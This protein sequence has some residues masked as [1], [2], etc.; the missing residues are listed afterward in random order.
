MANN[1]VMKWKHLSSRFIQKN[2][3][4]DHKTDCWLWQ[5]YRQSSGY[6]QTY[7]EGKR[8]LAHRLSWMAFKGPIPEGLNVLHKCDTKRCVNPAHL[9][10]GSQADNVKDC[11]DKGRSH[12]QKADC[13]FSFTRKPRKRRLTPW[14]ITKVK[15]WPYALSPLAEEMGVSVSYLSRIRKG[16]R[17]NLKTS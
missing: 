6:G 17:L 16:D 12:F 8:I 11:I 3:E 10:L 7:V 4:R 5:N 15:S 9:F 2:S 1:S 14:Q 13:D